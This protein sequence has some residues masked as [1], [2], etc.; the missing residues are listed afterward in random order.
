MTVVLWRRGGK[1]Q[2]R[3]EGKLLQWRRSAAKCLP[4][5]VELSSLLCQHLRLPVYLA[6]QVIHPRQQPLQARCHLLVPSDT[7]LLVCTRRWRAQGL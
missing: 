4:D 7:G 2:H 1:L 6:R 3:D 5:G